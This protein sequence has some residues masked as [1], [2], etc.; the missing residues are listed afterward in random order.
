MAAA[1]KSGTTP[2]KQGDKEKQLEN[3]QQVVIA[4]EECVDPLESITRL[5]C[6]VM[7]CGGTS[8]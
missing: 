1:P 4:K 7:Y 3:E 8:K 6:E 5:I 2:K